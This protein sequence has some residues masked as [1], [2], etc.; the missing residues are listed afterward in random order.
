MSF[1]KILL[2]HAYQ[3]G[4]S[5]ETALHSLVRLIEKSQKYQETA[6]CA[7]L[8][9]EG[10]FENTPFASITTA[11]FNRGVDSTTMSWIEAILS[12]SEISA[13]YIGEDSQHKTQAKHY[14]SS[15]TKSSQTDLQQRSQIS[16]HY[17]R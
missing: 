17:S 10:A 9:I 1:T 11:L 14:Y 12:S 3:H 5:T 2:Q 4:K 15:F 16:R 6:L 13:V 8:D 7:F